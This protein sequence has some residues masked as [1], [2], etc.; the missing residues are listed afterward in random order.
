MGKARRHEEFE[1]AIQSQEGPI[2]NYVFGQLFYGLGNQLTN[3]NL[4]RSPAKTKVHNIAK[5]QRIFDAI[6][7]VLL[8]PHI[9]IS[10]G[11]KFYC[12]YLTEDKTFRFF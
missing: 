5:I 4:T 10:M 12:L 2:D 1:R 9:A 11:T 3:L 8:N 7:P 6:N